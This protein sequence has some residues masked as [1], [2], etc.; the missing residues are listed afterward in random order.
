MHIYYNNNLIEEPYLQPTCSGF[1]F[2]YGVFETILVSKGLPC[3]VDLHYQR[4][5][6]GCSRLGLELNLDAETMRNQANRLAEVQNIESG[7][8][9]LICFRDTNQDSTMMTLYPYKMEEA[10]SQEGMSLRT[11]SI[12]RNSHS[13]LS[14]IK[15]LNYTENILAKEEAKS[16]GYHEALFLN[17][18]N[19]LCEGAVS[20]IFWVKHNKLYTPELSCGIL[21]GITRGQVIKICHDMNIGLEEGTFNIEELLQAEEVFITN[22]L[23]GI[24]PVSKVDNTNYNIAHYETTKKLYNEYIKLTKEEVYY[25]QGKDS[26]SC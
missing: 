11:S 7:R 4:L 9:K 22:S 8:L 16:Q 13:P 24:M 14:Y 3:F 18:N 6:R 25:G 21:D 2:G 1:Q 10:Y 17:T 19:K 23:M 15:S 5:Q 12:K 26:K 20:N